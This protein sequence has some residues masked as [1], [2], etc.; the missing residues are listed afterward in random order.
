MKH[1]LNTQRQKFPKATTT[2][3]PILYDFLCETLPLISSGLDLFPSLRVQNGRSDI[4]CFWGQRLR[5]KNSFCF[6]AHW[7]ASCHAVKNVEIKSWV[8][9]QHMQWERPCLGVGHETCE[10]SLLKPSS[11]AQ[12][13]SYCNFMRYLRSEEKIWSPRP[14]S[15]FW[16]TGSLEINKWL[17]F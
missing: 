12:L 11:S 3:S 8:V 15:N 1:H 2:V 7:K 5:G 9:R 10:R 4:V 16:P 14:C 6:Y 13:P 17:L